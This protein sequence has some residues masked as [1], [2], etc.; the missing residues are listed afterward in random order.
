MTATTSPIIGSLIDDPLKLPQAD[1]IQARYCDDRKPKHDERE[2]EHESLLARRLGTAG[3]RKLSIAI[4]VA[5]HK[6]FIKP[7]GPMNGSA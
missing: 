6:E 2:I 5:P 4:H 7:A 3:G 1:G